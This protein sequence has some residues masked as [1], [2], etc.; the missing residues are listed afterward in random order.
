MLKKEKTR[1]TRSASGDTLSKPNYRQIIENSARLSAVQLQVV[2]NF[3]D[4][5]KKW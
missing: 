4:N 5:Q 3:S 2:T 1:V